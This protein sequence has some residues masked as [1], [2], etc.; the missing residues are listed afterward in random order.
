MPTSRSARNRVVGSSLRG[1]ASA[2]RPVS[3]VRGVSPAHPAASRACDQH[4]QRLARVERRHVRGA[5]HE[6][7]AGLDEHPAAQLDLAAEVHDVRAQPPVARPADRP[8][9]AAPTRARADRRARPRPPPR[10]AAALATRAS[11]L[12]SAARSSAAAAG[13]CA[14]RRRA[15][16]ATASSAPAISASGPDRRGRQVPRALVEAHLVVE[17]A[18]QR[19]VRCA[20]LLR[21]TGPAG[22]PN[23]RAD[24][25]PRCGRRA[26][27]RARRARRPPARRRR[28]PPPRAA[29]ITGASR[30]AVLRR[31]EREHL[32]RRLRAAGAR[33]RGTAARRSASAAGCAATAPRPPAAARGQRL[34]QLDERQCVA[35]GLLDQH[36]RTAGATAPSAPRVDQRRR[37]LAVEPAAARAPARRGRRSGAPRPSRSANSITMPSA[38]S[39]RATN[40][41]APADDTSSHWAS[42]TRHSTGRCSASSDSSVGRR[43]RS[44]TGRRRALARPSAPRSAAA[45]AA[46]GGPPSAGRAGP[47]DAGPRTAAP[48]PT[49]RHEPRAR[50]CPTRAHGASSDSAVLPT[51]GSPRTTSAALREPLAASSSA[52]S[53]GAL[54]IPPVPTRGDPTQTRSIAEMRCA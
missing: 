43:P 38:S 50:A 39:R 16:S 24:D 54:H 33:A 44:G 26:P 10:R 4:L 36:P 23:A 12:S 47:A 51:P 52:L 40:S 27:R 17:D 11:G 31:D 53:C 41:S 28:C 49:R 34:R 29:R 1:S 19:E 9:R 37:R 13:A 21:S 3:T 20:A 6:D 46:A 30:S 32:L 22:S 5:G 8:G 14:L 7:V 45:W 35:A 15:R 25:A 48:T 18:G 42:S 2:R